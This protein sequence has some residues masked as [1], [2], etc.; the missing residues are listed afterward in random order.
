MVRFLFAQAVISFQHFWTFWQGAVVVLHG[1]VC[2]ARCDTF[3]LLQ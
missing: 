3:L 2:K 1:L